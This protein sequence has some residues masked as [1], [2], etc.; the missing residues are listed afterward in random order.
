MIFAHGP[1]GFLTAWTLQKSLS[2]AL[3]GR[4]R[5]W[6]LMTGFVA[7]IFPD[8]DLFFYYFVDASGSHRQFITHTPVFYLVIF[9]V[10]VI[11]LWLFKRRSWLIWPGVFLFGV[12]SHLLTDAIL[13]QVMF[14]YPF[15]DNFYGLSDLAMVGF[16]EKLFFINFLVEGVFCF[17]FFYVLIW[18]LTKTVK[19]RWIFTGVLGIVFLSG[20]TM[21]TYIDLHTYHTNFGFYYN[22]LDADG[23]PNFEDRDIDGDGELNIDDLDSDG[24]GESNPFEIT[25]HAEGFV[26]VLYDPTNGGMAQ[27]PARL[28]LVTNEDIVRRLYTLVGINLRDE[29]SVDYSLN[30]SGYEL[31]PQDSQFDRSK[32]NLQTWI[33]HRGLL[34][35]GEELKEGRYQLG[36]VLFFQSGYVAVTTSFD[37]KGQ[38]MVLDVQK[39]RPALE[40]YVTDVEQDEG[41]VVARGK[42]LSAAPLFEKQD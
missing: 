14:F 29:F 1:A 20:V 35:T 21:L 42:L 3:V 30:A 26:G 27:I 24:D 32:H 4:K 40:R 36:D 13:A 33:E 38:A 15:T 31:T 19:Q 2:P 34:E 7:G 25:T 17:F 5:W 9:T 12:M 28:G 22:D 41:S 8:I 10:I 6:L 18:E 39:H 11:G 23:I 37:N 16:S